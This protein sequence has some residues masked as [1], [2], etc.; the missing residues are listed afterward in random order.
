VTEEVLGSGVRHFVRREE[1]GGS[2]RADMGYLVPRDILLR[3]KR[4]SRT[5]LHDIIVD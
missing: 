5:L 1:R 3:G 2:G 4:M